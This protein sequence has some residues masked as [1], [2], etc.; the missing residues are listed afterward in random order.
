MKFAILLSAAFLFATPVCFAETSSTIPTLDSKSFCIS[1][2]DLNGGSRTSKADCVATEADAKTRV[3]AFWSDTDETI[4]AYCEH[5]VRGVGAAY[6]ALVHCV[7][8]ENRKK[9][10]RA[11]F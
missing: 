4:Q 8:A 7:Q 3:E 9:S 5:K 1:V 6:I 11:D 10:N 2:G